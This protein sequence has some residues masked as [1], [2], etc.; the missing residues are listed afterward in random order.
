MSP[1]PKVFRQVNR[2][3]LAGDQGVH[4]PSEPAGSQDIG[5]ADPAPSRPA[6][7]PA[8]WWLAATT[9]IALPIALH[10]LMD[11][12]GQAPGRPGAASG[13]GDTS[14]LGIR[15]ARP[16]RLLSTATAAR[17]RPPAP[18]QLLAVFSGLPSPFAGAQPPSEQRGG[19]GGPEAA[20]TAGGA[21]LL[22]GPLTLADRIGDSLEAYQQI[23]RQSRPIE[24]D[25]TDPLPQRWAEHLR[26]LIKSTPLV[27]PLEV[28]RVQSSDIQASRTIP[29]ALWPDG[30]ATTNVASP[31]QVGQ[32]L[33]EAWVRQQPAL[34]EGS[35]R[36]VLMVLEPQAGEA[37]ASAA[38]ERP[39]A[40]QPV[41]KRPAAATTAAIAVPAAGEVP[42]AAAAPEPAAAPPAEPV[43]AMAADGAAGLASPELSAA[44]PAPQ[45]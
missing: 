42:A 28:V 38:A 29:L 43:A 7:R 41:A 40:E 16:A 11:D 2:A 4:P 22:G 9:G 26:A 13:D 19:V 18:D 45:P 21:S 14:P 5:S 10:P 12:L 32:Q 36:P 23:A 33:A 37:G 34:I 15:Q 1:L 25:T 20:A 6:I 44:A 27:L 17:P 30:S 3:R 31:G 8:V 35:V 24:V 39:V